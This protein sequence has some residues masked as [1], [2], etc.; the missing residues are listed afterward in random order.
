MCGYSLQELVEGARFQSILN[1]NYRGSLST[2]PYQPFDLGLRCLKPGYQ[3]LDR[4][5]CILRYRQV[6]ELPKWPHQ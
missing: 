6:I 5:H 4:L 3:F 1:A 2:E